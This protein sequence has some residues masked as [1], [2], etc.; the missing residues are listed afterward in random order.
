M[1]GLIY[2]GVVC[3]ILLIAAVLLYQMFNEEKRECNHIYMLYSPTASACQLCGKEHPHSNKMPALNDRYSKTLGSQ[4]R[5][6]R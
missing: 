6:W 5:H 4:M 1:A 2:F 3:V